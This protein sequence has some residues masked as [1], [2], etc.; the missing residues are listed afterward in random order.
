M[1]KKSNP[2][3]SIFE[4]LGKNPGPKDLEQM[5]IILD[6]IPE[7]LNLPLPILPKIVA[8]TPAGTA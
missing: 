7:I 5:T 2:Q 1:R 4:V 8:Q 3:R 6:A